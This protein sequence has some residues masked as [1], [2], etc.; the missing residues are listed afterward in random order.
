MSETNE[1]AIILGRPD[2]DLPLGDPEWRPGGELA[3][4]GHDGLPY[5]W[6][7][8]GD[9]A[10]LWA[11]AAS[12]GG[13]RLDHPASRDAGECC[14]L[15]RQAQARMRAVQSALLDLAETLLSLA[16]ETPSQALN[17]R[18]HAVRTRLADELL[19]FTDAPDDGA[20][21][22]FRPMPEVVA[23]DGAP[24]SDEDR[25]KLR[26]LAVIL[27]E[28]HATLLGIEDPDALLALAAP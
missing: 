9:R 21:A 20:Y 4:V 6:R 25:R 23:I 16:G 10:S 22:I 27:L 18:L 19:M 15:L 28:Q 1:V 7:F 3:T 17:E 13:I 2:Y 11:P 14:A 5:L 24:K 8:D 26:P 12:L